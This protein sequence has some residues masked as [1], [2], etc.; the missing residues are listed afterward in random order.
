MYSNI[1]I[2]GCGLLGSMLAPPMASYIVSLGYETTV[3]LVDNDEIEK[4]N[5]PSN[6][7]VPHNIGEKKVDVVSRV[8]DDAGVKVVKRYDRLTP[9]SAWMLKKATLIIG[10]LDNVET[11][12]LI[13]EYAMENDIPYLDLGLS[14]TGGLVTWTN[15]NVK[16]MPFLN[17]KDYKVDEEK[18]PACELIGT[19]IYSA[20]VCEC[21]AMSV[22]IYLS[23][24]D[25]LSVVP[26][27]V[28]RMAQNGD[29]VNWNIVMDGNQVLTISQYVGNKGG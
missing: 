1:T 23:Q 4:R 24:H 20:A 26:A 8:Y 28:K 5:S 10:A 11:R 16:T 7:G 21:A 2:V 9:G 15:G 12:L 17:N 22:F 13:A 25:P 29:M 19:R 18:K 27:L 6:L 14:F 3:T